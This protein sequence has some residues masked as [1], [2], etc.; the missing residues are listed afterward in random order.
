ML[1]GVYQDV[2]R[3]VEKKGSIALT[4]RV[5]EAIALT[6]FE[7]ASAGECDPRRMRR[8]AAREVEAYGGVQLTLSRMAAPAIS[9]SV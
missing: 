5:R 9:A 3:G 1:T 7:M 6:I 4:A 8:R 2:C